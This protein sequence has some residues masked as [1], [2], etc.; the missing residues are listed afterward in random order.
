MSRLR[1]NPAYRKPRA[2]AKKQEMRK[3]GEGLLAPSYC[4]LG[5]A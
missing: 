5:C 4:N 1:F 3:S 2:V